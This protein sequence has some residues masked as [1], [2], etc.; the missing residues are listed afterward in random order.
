MKTGRS[1]SAKPRPMAT[2]G[3]ALIRRKRRRRRMARLAV[4]A[5]AA[6]SLGWGAYQLPQALAHADRFRLRALE[7]QGLRILEG[8]D[9]LAASGL[10]TGDNLFALD[11]P[12]VRNN[13]EQ[14][15][16]VQQVRLHRKPPDRLSIRITERQR[17]A[18]VE[19]DELYGVDSEGV[20]LPGN[21][22]AKES[23]QDLDLPVISGLDFTWDA[24]DPGTVLA[25]SSLASLLHWWQQARSAD[26]DFALTIS[27][28]QPLGTDGV[29]LRLVGDGLEIRMRRDQVRARIRT[30]RAL[31]QRVYRECPSPVYIDLRFAGQAVVGTKVRG[32]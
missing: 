12:Q 23:L 8:E 13:I 31:I 29:R 10:R 22:M 4:C 2:S 6:G 27:E 19:L 7:V 18:W 1:R 9:I 28:I 26:S 17:Q 15:P 24:L 3:E 14:L 20:V 21:R 16:W 25:D 30:L 5:V 32:S 11:L